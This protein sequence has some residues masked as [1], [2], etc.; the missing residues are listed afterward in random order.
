[1]V[2]TKEQIDKMP[3]I[4]DD[5]SGKLVAEE[6]KDI[7]ERDI[8]N[9]K[10]QFKVAEELW[11]ILE[12]P[13]TYKKCEPAWEFEKNPRYWELQ[14]KQNQYKIRSERHRSQSTLDGMYHQKEAIL[15]DMLDK[16][17]KLAKLNE[18]GEKNE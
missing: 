9:F 7:L 16:Q 8:E 13:E 11:K 4:T 18:E 15:K 10:E 1:M 12:N 17:E 6:L 3:E 2:E 5:S 14:H